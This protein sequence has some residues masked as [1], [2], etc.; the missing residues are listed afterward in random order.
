MTY[1]FVALAWLISTSVF[2]L[3][4]LPLM[5][6]FVDD[7]VAGLTTMVKVYAITLAAVGLFQIEV[8]RIPEERCWRAILPTVPYLV[9]FSIVLSLVVF[10]QGVSQSY[11]KSVCV[12]AIAVLGFVLMVLGIVLSL[13]D[14]L[15]KTTIAVQ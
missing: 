11:G 14:S 10:D 5:W 4:C 12:M 7:T 2:L 1:W 9:G 15:K 8:I 6:L 13:V 3:T